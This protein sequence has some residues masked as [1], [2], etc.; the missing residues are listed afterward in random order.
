MLKKRYDGMVRIKEFWDEN[1]KAI[2]VSPQWNPLTSKCRKKPV[3]M[4]VFVNFKEAYQF[5]LIS[6]QPI[7]AENT[8][9]WWRYEFTKSKLQSNGKMRYDTR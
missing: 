2:F 9:F 8:V 6:E 3:F 7:Y 1:M 4:R 5:L